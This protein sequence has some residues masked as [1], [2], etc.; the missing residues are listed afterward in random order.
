MWVRCGIFLLSLYENFD[1]CMQFYLTGL[2]PGKHL[3]K[4]LTEMREHLHAM[5]N[6]FKALVQ[7]FRLVQQRLGKLLLF[8]CPEP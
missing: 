4:T 7:L 1:I 2:V 3:G 8:Q 5:V 6:T